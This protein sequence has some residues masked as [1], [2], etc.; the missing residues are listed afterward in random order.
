MIK[1][2]NSVIDYINKH[3]TATFPRTVMLEGEVGSGRHSICNLIAEKFNL[4]VEDISDS[5]NY[6]KIEEITL[7]V[8]P[9]LYIIDSN[10]LTVKNENALLKFMEEPLKNS[11]IILISENRYNEIE[12]IRNRCHIISLCKY[13]TE[14]LCEFIVDDTQKN[15]ILTICKTPG[16]VIKL[17]SYPIK[18]MLDYSIKIYEKIDIASYANTMSISNKIAFKNE[19]DKFDFELF[20]RCLLYIAKIR[21]I[22]KE[23]YSVQD[24]TISHKYYIMS[25]LKNVDKKMLFENFLLNLKKQRC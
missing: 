6:D 1:Y 4:H 21:V 23:P 2:Q 17:Q 20:F 11:F 13:T 10:K 9:Y 3:T 22:N 18:D 25:K 12:T 14:Q 15:V 19:K 24:Y 8:E 5:I 7:K 16:D